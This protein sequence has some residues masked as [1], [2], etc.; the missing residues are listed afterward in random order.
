MTSTLT[1]RYVWAVQRSLPEGKRADIDKELRGS[2]AD[3]IDAKRDA[4]EAPAKAERDAI[5]ELGDPYRLALGYTDRPLHL[6]GPAV[7]PDYIRLLKV[8]YAIVLPIAFAGIVLG[9]LLGKVDSFTT[10]NFG[11]VIGSTFA[12]IIT[13]AVHFGFW[14]TL[15]FALIERS[16]QYRPTAWNPDTLPTVPLKGSIKLSEFLAGV[17]WFVLSIGFLIWAQFISLFRAEDG[18]AVPVFTQ[19]LWHFW[20]PFFIAL[21]ALQLVFQFVLYR[22][23]HWTFRF[24]ATNAALTLAFTAPALWLILSGGWINP[25][26]LSRI[27]ITEL[28]A[29]NG[30]VTI[31][32]VIVFLI[33][34]TAT[35]IDGFVKAVRGAR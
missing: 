6:I 30:A 27:G 33:I 25:E 8:L 7:F 28:F 32:L 13:V 12:A 5:L 9:Q 31:V 29:P 20:I 23:G 10:A 2:I 19:Q 15:V 22:R 17:V 21:A 26:F 24:A 16:P 35:S 34:A 14:T 1:D 4:G 11:P 18:S 3:A